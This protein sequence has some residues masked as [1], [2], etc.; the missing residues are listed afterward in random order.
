MDPKRFAGRI[1]LEPEPL[2]KGKRPRLFVCL[3]SPIPGS[4][5]FAE[6]APEMSSVCSKSEFEALMTDVKEFV[7]K[8]TINKCCYDASLYCGI[9]TGGLLCI[10]PC[11]HKRGIMAPGL[12]KILKKHQSVWNNGTYLSLKITESSTSTTHNSVDQYGNPLTHNALAANMNVDLMQKAY[13]DAPAQIQHLQATQIGGATVNGKLVYATAHE[14]AYDAMIIEQH[15]R[16]RQ[17]ILDTV[18]S[19]TA[20]WPPMGYAIVL[21]CKD[22]AVRAQWPK[23]PAG[24]K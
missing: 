7:E 14:S 19:D 4:F 10:W 23:L 21:E 15:K 3:G 6:Y 2:H 9:C 12:S 18:N 8:H 16:G 17:V 5:K 11:Y 24:E 13:V 22:E 20:F 1:F